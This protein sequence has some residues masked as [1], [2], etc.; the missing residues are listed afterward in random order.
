M[1]K[2][3]VMGLMLNE[4]GPWTGHIEAP[5]EEAAINQAQRTVYANHY[6]LEQPELYPVL[7]A[8][9]VPKVLEVLMVFDGFVYG[10]MADELGIER[11]EPTEPADYLLTYPHATAGELA[12]FIKQWFNQLKSPEQVVLAEPIELNL[13]VF[14]GSQPVRIIALTPTGAEVSGAVEQLDLQ[15]LANVPTTYYFNLNT[16]A[17]RR[18][19]QA[20]A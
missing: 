8:H 5:D 13:G 20:L 2:F 16:A 4:N 11:V 3:T 6:L 18:I 15:R 17:L 14:G 7:P 1:K 10:I 12:E 19:V 9:I